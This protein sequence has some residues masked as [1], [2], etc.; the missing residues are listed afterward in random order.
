MDQIER[1]I[2]GPRND[3]VLTLQ[4]KHRSRRVWEE[5]D[6]LDAKVFCCRYDA[7]VESSYEDDRI[8]TNLRTASFY[9]V[10]RVQPIKLDHSLITALLERWRPE[11]HSFQ[12]P[13]GEL[14]IT[15]QDVECLLGLPVDGSQQTKDAMLDRI[16]EKFFTA[17]NKDDSYRNRDQLTSKWSHINRKWQ[18]LNNPDGGSFQKRSTVDAEVEVDETIGSTDQI[19]PFNVGDSDNEDP[20][21]R[22]IGKKKAKSI[23]SGSRGSGSVSVSSRDEISWEIVEQLRAFNFREQ[24]R[25]KLKEKKLKLKEQEVEMKVMETDISTLS[26]I[27]RMLYEQ[28]IKEIKE[29]YNFP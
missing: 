19:S 11:V 28:R 7:G 5:E 14:G 1:D 2:A 24:E 13:F 23:A 9:G 18:Q 27:G 15:L 4:Q 20:I 16:E 25:L 29:N 8:E 3:A 26:E 12:F 6:F 21:P 17:M 10:H 22:P